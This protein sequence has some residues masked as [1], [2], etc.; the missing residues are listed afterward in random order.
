MYTHTVSV[1]SFPGRCATL[2]MVLV[3]TQIGT[4]RTSGV[5]EGGLSLPG[6]TGDWHSGS[7]WKGSLEVNVSSAPAPAGQTA[8]EHLRARRPQKLPGHP[9]LG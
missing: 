1:Y 2:H 7:R 3:R 5:G 9:E 6:G 4:V 8:F